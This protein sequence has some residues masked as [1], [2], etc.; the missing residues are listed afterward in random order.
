MI[1]PLSFVLGLTLTLGLAIAQ[2][3]PGQFANL[4]DSIVR[5]GPDSQLPPHLSLFLGLSPS[6]KS[7]PVKQQVVRNNHGV[8]AFS[9][10]VAN[11]N[12]LVILNHDDRNQVTKAYL[13]SGAGKLRKAVVYQDKT[14]V[15]E[16]SLRDSR[17]DFF[18]EI[19]FWSDIASGNA[20]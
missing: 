19:K 16:R 18:N 17:S 12:D 9:V 3:V 8:R 20:H 5:Q 2:A 14:P 11:H 1:R 6:G 7:T 4:V 15:R 13:I 10:C